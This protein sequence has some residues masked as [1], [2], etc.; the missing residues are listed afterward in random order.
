MLQNS[1]RLVYESAQSPDCEHRRKSQARIEFKK[2]ET[3]LKLKMSKLVATGKWQAVWKPNMAKAL[4]RPK[5]GRRGEG[6]VTTPET[7]RIESE[8][9]NEKSQEP[10]KIASE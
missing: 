2:S 3:V 9:E 7:P 5:S 8:I 4:S 6:A 1:S 10:K